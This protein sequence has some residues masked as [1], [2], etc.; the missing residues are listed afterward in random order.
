MI[1]PIDWANRWRQLVI[2]REEQSAR[3]RGNRPAEP[4]RWGQ[5]AQR[6][7]KLTQELRPDEPFLTV[8]RANVTPDDEVLDIGAGAGRYAVTIAPYVK[9]VYAFEPSPAMLNALKMT[10]AERGVSNVEP[11]PGNWPDDMNNVPPADVVFA[12]HSCY[13]TTDIIGFVKAMDAKARRLGMM[14]IRVLPAEAY[15][16]DLP[17]RLRGEP[18]AL[19]PVFLDLLGALGQAGIWPN[20]NIVHGFP[21]TY[22]SMDELVTNVGS[23]L[24]CDPDDIPA[25]FIREYVRNVVAEKN[26]R[27]QLLHPWNLTANLC[28]TKTGG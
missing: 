13:W 21:R 27:L 24:S 7:M 9:K 25:D 23:L 3:W 22:G 20:T 28:W 15:L 11:V 17:K 18:R 12:S 10:I 8:L 2:E 19:E 6:F 1:E 4:D 16:G 26:G 5:S 14:T